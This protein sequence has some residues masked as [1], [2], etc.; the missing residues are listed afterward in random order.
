MAETASVTTSAPAESIADKL[1]Q[2]GNS[3]KLSD[4]QTVLGF[5]RHPHDEIKALASKTASAIVKENLITRYKQM[6]H[7]VRKKLVM[8]LES[9]DS[10][11]ID[12]ISQ[13]LYSDAHERRLNAIQ[14][15]GLLKKNP[16][17]KDILATLI[18]DRDVKVRA[19]AVH[20]LGKVIGP[21]D[22]NTIL[23]LLSDSDKRVRANTI[24]GLEQVGNKRLVPIL[25]RFRNDNNNRIRGN[26]LK[27]LFNL[28][29]TDIEHDLLAMLSNSSDLM[30]ATALWVIAQIK[31]STHKLVDATG[32]LVLS[33]NAM[34]VRNAK[35]ALV[36]QGTPRALGYLR[37]L[38]LHQEQ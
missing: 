16:R 31:V 17:T 38:G 30:K 32:R 23:T 34:V 15:L 13:D 28:G 11:V 14:I 9:L 4:L 8:L 37:Y 26:I 18:K 10:R 36:A 5:I 19:T 2:L 21:N 1:R 29:F 6:D 35:N 7:D 22:F 3:G 25:L 20:L 27:A 12:E 33:D 24:E